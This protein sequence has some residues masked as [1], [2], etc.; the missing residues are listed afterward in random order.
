MLRPDYCTVTERVP[1][2]VVISPLTAAEI[3][4][5]PV[6]T[7]RSATPP[8]PTVVGELDCPERI[9]TVCGDPVPPALL[10]RVAALALVLVKLT[11]K[12]PPGRPARTPWTWFS[13][14]F[15]AAAVPTRT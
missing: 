14:P 8:V 11:V 2:P 7:R 4:L 10:T 6:A 5:V 15:P 9:K 1:C 3:E 13:D 12:D